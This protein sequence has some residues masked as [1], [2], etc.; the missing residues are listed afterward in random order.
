MTD[1]ML[2]L[3]LAI[4]LWK[5]VSLL[6]HLVYFQSA[7]LEIFWAIICHTVISWL[8]IPRTESGKFL[9]LVDYL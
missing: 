5:C 9:N 7:Y 3:D 1:E 8:S 2:D 6:P 4:P